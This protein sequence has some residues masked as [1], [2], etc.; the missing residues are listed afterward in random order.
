VAVDPRWVSRSLEISHQELLLDSMGP[1]HG[2][3][4]GERDRRPVSQP[5]RTTAIDY[6]E[7]IFQVP[8]WVPE[9]SPRSSQRMLRGLLAG[10][11]DYAPAGNADAAGQPD[12][13]SALAEL[14]RTLPY[15]EEDARRAREVASEPD[16]SPSSLLITEEELR[17]LVRAAPMA[18]KSPRQVKQLTNLYRLVKVSLGESEL[19]RLL[20][21]SAGTPGCASVT[22]L[23]AVAIGAAA[24]ADDFF[25]RITSMTE[26]QTLADLLD[27][28]EAEGDAGPGRGAG[29]LAAVVP[30]IREILPEEPLRRD[31]L[32]YWRPAVRRYTFASGSLT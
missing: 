4:Q 3:D 25:D 21:K 32:L 13:A 26:E 24:V 17:C 9:F 18:G 7:K 10:Q 22:L 29:G 31:D 27:A 20:G 23:L 15:R 6:L 12:R 11:L 5:T 16:L 8:Y 28:I 19:D 1:D 14:D 2:H 30:R